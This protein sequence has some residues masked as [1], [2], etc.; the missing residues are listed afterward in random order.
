[1]SGTSYRGIAADQDTRFKDKTK[2]GLKSLG[3]LPNHYNVKV[4]IRKVAIQLI[5][6]WIHNKVED[7]LGFQDE[8]VSEYAVSLLTQQGEYVSQRE[9]SLQGVHIV[10][11]ISLSFS[12][13]IQRNFNST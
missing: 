11:L 10:S 8:M 13:Q 12:S 6:P 7:L 2:S 9:C 5:T 4:D 1:M 3:K